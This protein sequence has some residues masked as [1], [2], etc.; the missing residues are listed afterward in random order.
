MDMD[1]KNSVFGG[2]KFNEIVFVN[3][4]FC[5]SIQYMQAYQD[6]YLQWGL[7]TLLK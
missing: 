5:I 4:D 6:L 3:L 1:A 7:E 2:K